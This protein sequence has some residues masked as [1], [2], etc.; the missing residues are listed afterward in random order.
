MS[1]LADFS[2]LLEVAH[3]H[4]KLSSTCRNKNKMAADKDI[5]EP[6]CKRNVSKTVLWCLE[7]V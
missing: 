7:Q 5:Y 6:K 2:A 3:V 4:K 1:H